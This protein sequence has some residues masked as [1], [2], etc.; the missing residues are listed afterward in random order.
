M[1]LEPLTPPTAQKLQARAV[2]E[3]CADR[4]VP[5]VELA[6]IAQPSAEK[7]VLPANEIAS[8]ALGWSASTQTGRPRVTVS[9]RERAWVVIR[10]MPKA[11][12]IAVRTGLVALT[13]T[14]SAV[15]VTVTVRWSRTSTA[16]A[17]GGGGGGRLNM[18]VATAMRWA[19][20]ASGVRVAVRAARSA[21]ACSF[22]CSSDSRL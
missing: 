19:S 21:S 3:P 16:G 17:P 4:A 5:L 11:L 14:L 10:W 2:A 20:E 18:E 8:R 12:S 22:A 7:V 15:A 13:V 6:W 9:A 1:R